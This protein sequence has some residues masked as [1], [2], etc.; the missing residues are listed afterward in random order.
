MNRLKTTTGVT[1]SGQTNTLARDAGLIF[2]EY[3]D[4]YGKRIPY[5]R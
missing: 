4:R 3:P 5:S 1:Y 2:K